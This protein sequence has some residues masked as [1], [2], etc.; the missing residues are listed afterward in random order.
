MVQ[1]KKALRPTKG[2]VAH[3]VAKTALSAIPVVG[4]PAAE[5]FAAIIAPPLS[6]RRDK[7]IEEIASAVK[8]L[9]DQVAEV[10][11]EKLSK[12]DSFITTL[13]YATQIASRN[14]QE[15]KLGALRNAVMNAALPNA[16]DE[17][18]QQVFLNHVDSLTPWHLSILSFF[19]NPERWAQLNGVTYPSWT[20]GGASQVLEHSFPQLRGRREIYDQYV[21]DLAARGLFGGSSWLHSMMSRQGMF[22]SRT[23]ALG[24]AFLQFISKPNQ[25][26]AD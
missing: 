23:T 18:L 13:L 25:T 9:Q 5:I 16:P 1:P 3:T 19:D 7:W 6:K 14:H 21:N 11:P 2:D 10:T 26:I 12:N 20:A 8:E 15:E 4:G 17:D 22:S 24:K